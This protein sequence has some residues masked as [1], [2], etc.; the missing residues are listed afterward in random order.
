MHW[1]TSEWPWK[2]N[3]QKYPYTA[4]N[5]YPPNTNFIQFR[6]TTNRFFEMLGCENRK[7]TE[8]PQTDHEPLAANS[9]LFVYTPEAPISLRFTLPWLFFEILAVCCFLI[10][11]K[12]EPKTSNIQQQHFCNSTFVRTMEEKIQ[13][14]FGI[15][16]MR[17][18]GVVF[19]IFAPIGFHRKEN[20]KKN[21][22][23]AVTQ[24]FKNPKQSCCDV[25][26]KVIQER[27]EIIWKR[28]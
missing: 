15:F 18:E 3:C 14:K 17:F 2:L 25:Y 13:E 7:C 9:T 12:S 8:L 20:R 10:W 26:V 16:Q 11:Y 27:F 5:T 28:F 23:K 6:S 21:R 22:E 1:M 4:L 24:N 19:W